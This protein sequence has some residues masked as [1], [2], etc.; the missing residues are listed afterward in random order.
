MFQSDLS[1]LF[2]PILWYDPP[3]RIPLWGKMDL[4]GSS[5]M[6]GGPGRRVLSALCSKRATSVGVSSS[7]NTHHVL[8]VRTTASAVTASSGR[9]ARS[10]H[11][12]PKLPAGR[13]LG[14]RRRIMVK[15][16]V[17]VSGRSLR[18]GDAPRPRP[19]QVEESPQLFGMKGLNLR[20]SGMSMVPLGRSMI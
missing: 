7:G 14:E 12:D 13:G 20:L 16:R 18:R 10:E 1:I 2:K 17:K 5:Y 6:G 19:S 8:R 4:V 15:R 11:S 9:E 3:F